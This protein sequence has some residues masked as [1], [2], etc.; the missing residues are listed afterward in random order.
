M[1][2]LPVQFNMAD[3]VAIIQMDDGKANALSYPMLDALDEALDRAQAEADAVVIVGRE[4]RFS[5]GF[6]L[7]TMTASAEDAIQLLTRGAALYTRLYGLPIPL[8]MA[9][10]GHAIAGGALLLLCGDVRFG[11]DAQVKVGL[12]ELNIGMP[13]PVL[14]IELAEKRLKP[15]ALTQATLCARMYGPHEAVTVGYLDHVVPPAQL[16][17][18]AVET[19]G[20]LTQFNR[21]AFAETKQRLR[22]RSI[23]YIQSTLDGDMARFRRIMS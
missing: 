15:E 18:A 21:K 17:D 22:G 12:N 5:A 10:S 19:A 9:C 11:I 23:Q 1:S 3:N 8:V 6:D 20:Q 2:N 16:I 13:L 7:K 14:A 4:G